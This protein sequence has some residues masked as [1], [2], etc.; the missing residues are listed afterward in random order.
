MSSSAR[1]NASL[2]V[3]S[4]SSF[5]PLRNTEICDDDNEEYIPL[6]TSRQ[7]SLDDLE[8]DLEDDEEDI[9]SVPRGRR[10]VT[11]RLLPPCNFKYFVHLRSQ[12]RAFVNLPAHYDANFSKPINLFLFFFTNNM[13]DTIVTNTNL[14]SLS[15]NADGAGRQ[16]QNI[17]RKELII[18][19]ALVIY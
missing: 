4:S 7:H 16:W 18:W 6:L 14:Y 1:P 9:T 11:V 8:Q 10:K 5:S 13:L 2:T 19:I 12:Y 17:T 3:S 15:K